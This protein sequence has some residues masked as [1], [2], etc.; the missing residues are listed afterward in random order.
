[1]VA[2]DKKGGWRR[3]NITDLPEQIFINIFD[4]IGDKVS[5]AILDPY[6]F[7]QVDS[8]SCQ[9]VA[10]KNCKMVAR[11]YNSYETE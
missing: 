3:F 8:L 6:L 11:F 5:D 4:Q 1:M 10:G 7:D 2:C 9:T